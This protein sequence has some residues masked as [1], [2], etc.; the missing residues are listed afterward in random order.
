MPDFNNKI[1][2]L[3]AGI[4]PAIQRGITLLAEYPSVNKV[5]NIQQDT[6]TN[7]VDVV[8]SLQLGLPNQWMAAGTSPNGVLAVEPVT[9]SFL[10]TYPIHAPIV[11]LRA[12]FDRSLAHIQPDS[13]PQAVLPC[14]Y[15]GDIDELLH[16]Q[17]LWAIVDRVV[18]WLEKAALNQ[19]IDPNQGWEPIRRDSLEDVIIADSDYLFNLVSR[20]DSFVFLP[21][22]YLKIKKTVS[23]KSSSKQYF[24]FGRIGTTPVKFKDF[25]DIFY[26]E[27][28]S[29]HLLSGSSLTLVITPDKLPSGE[30]QIASQYFPESV[31]DIGSLRRVSASQTLLTR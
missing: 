2:S 31:T 8:V 7:C 12:N 21:F 26:E 20:G 24:I 14:L 23:L 27:K 29:S 6:K 17:G 15:D 28:I 30:L 22:T 11:K 1:L 19:L 25:V 13:S 3:P 4:N 10:Q 5:L 18:A 9:F 16:S